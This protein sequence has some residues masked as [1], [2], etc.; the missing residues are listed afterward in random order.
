ME[1]LYRF[2]GG[3]KSVGSCH[4]SGCHGFFRPFLER[5]PPFLRI[6][7]SPKVVQNYARETIREAFFVTVCCQEV[8]R[9]TPRGNCEGS[10]LQY[11][12]ARLK[13]NDEV[14]AAAMSQARWPHPARSC[15]TI[16]E[17]RQPKQKDLGPDIRAEVPGSFVRTSRVKSFGQALKTLEKQAFG[18][19]HP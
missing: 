4:I 7:G 14:V 8:R 13:D 11:G 3:E 15:D 10:A 9:V 17:Q 12:S 2:Q 19:R 6:L 1:K 18:C 16:P 5:I